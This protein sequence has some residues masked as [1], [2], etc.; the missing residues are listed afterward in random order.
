MLLL[1][2]GGSGQVGAEIRTL[3]LPRN[4]EVAAPDRATLDLTNEESVTAVITS[5]PWSAVINAAAYT[6]VDGAED[7][8]SAAFA[9]NARAPLCLAKA[10]ASRDIPLIHISTDF[11]FDGNKGKPY[12]ETDGTAPLNVYGRSKLAGEL[13]VST[14]NPQHI[15]LRTSWMHSPF[16]KNFVRTII[17]LADERERLAIVNDQR[18]CPT[19]ARDVARACVEI[20]QQCAT[21]PGEIPY[22]CYHYAGLGEATWF[23]FAQTII[24]TAASR[25]VRKPEVVPIV[26]ADYP[27]PAKRPSDTRLDCAAICRV[28][29]VQL[30]PWRD[31]VYETIDR[32]VTGNSR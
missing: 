2:L 25:I 24:E 20:A 15:I 10:T 3:D 16:R 19:A 22:G 5:E 23:E 13:A 29:N 21:N 6:D 12:V 7:D 11:V 18:G 8:Q 32:L 31:G 4:V 14:T 17:H 1:V 27:T 26:T 30:R 9:L 28:F